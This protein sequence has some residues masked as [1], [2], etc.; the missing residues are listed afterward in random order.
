MVQ[1]SQKYTIFR[2]IFQSFSGT[3]PGSIFCDFM[4]TFGQKVRFGSPLAAK[5]GSQI[6]PWADLFL[7]K[8]DFSF[9]CFPGETSLDRPWRDLRHKDAFL[10]IWDDLGMLLDG[11]WLQK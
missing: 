3:P 11:F 5:L 4:P 6:D 7:Q 9:P 1:A 8:T 10:S 2:S